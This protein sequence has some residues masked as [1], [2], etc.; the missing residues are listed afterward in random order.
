VSADAVIWARAVQLPP[1]PKIVLHVLAGLA[2][3]QSLCYPSL[4]DLVRLT[5]WKRRSV[6]RAIRTL[7]HHKLLTVSPRFMPD[8]GQLTNLYRLTLGAEWTSLN[9]FSEAM[10]PGFSSHRCRKLLPST[11]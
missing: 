1:C 6:Q 10:A 3:E 11:R 4:D 9:A 8:V 7:V 2:N 5:I